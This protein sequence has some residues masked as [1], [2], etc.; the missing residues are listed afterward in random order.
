MMKTNQPLKSETPDPVDDAAQ[1]HGDLTDL[2]GELRVMLPG[3]QMLTA[4][5]IV[6]PFNSGFQQII[7][8]EKV[9]FLATFFLALTSLVLLSGP[10]IQHRIMT[11]LRDRIGF[12]RMAMRQLIAGGVALALAF[13]LATILVMSEVFG[14]NPGIIAGVAV[15]IL[16]TC[17]WLLLPLFMRHHRR[18]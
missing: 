2:L 5:L 4:F 16:I 13:V 12:K 3:A 15:A 7:K 10:A 9:I 18:M 6:L 8:A 14:T 11:P 17:L 1:E